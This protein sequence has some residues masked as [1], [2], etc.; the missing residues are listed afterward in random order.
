MAIAASACEVYPLECL[1]TLCCPRV[2]RRAARITAAFPYQIAERKTDEADSTSFGI[3]QKMFDESRA[4]WYIIGSYHSHPCYTTRY[5][6]HST[7]SEADLESMET[8]DLEIIVH[9]KRRRK[10]RMNYWRTTTAGNISVAWG[11]FQFLIRGFI[12]V[13][14]SGRTSGLQYRSVPLELD[15]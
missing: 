3:F 1:G 5:N 6:I 13:E 10:R 11:K 9:T 15:P 4:P 2:P 14:G 12:K 7:P 8:G